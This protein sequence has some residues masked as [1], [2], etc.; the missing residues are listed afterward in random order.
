MANLWYIGFE[1]LV[2]PISTQLHNDFEVL[3]VLLRKFLVIIP[4]WYSPSLVTMVS[5]MALFGGFSGIKPGK[6]DELKLQKDA[7]LSANLCRFYF[8]KAPKLHFLER[9]ATRHP[10]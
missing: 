10:P 8:L 5:V 9:H 2:T 1:V 7:S 3:Y 6:C 4:F